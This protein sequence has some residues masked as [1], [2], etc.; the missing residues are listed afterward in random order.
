MS[1]TLSWSFGL[2]NHEGKYL[3]VETFHSMIN[4]NSKVMKKKQIFFLEKA[5]GENQVYIRTWANKYLAVDADGTFSA[6][7]ED[8]SADAALT[9]LPQPDGSWALVSHRLQYIHGAGDKM[10]ALIDREISDKASTKFVVH[11][12]MHPQVNIRNVNRKRYLHLNGD[13][14]TCDE[15]VPWGDDAVL[16]LDFNSDGSYSIQTAAGTFLHKD[17]LLS[18]AIGEDNKFVL[19]FH[20]SELAFKSKS[21]GMYLTCAGGEG[22]TRALKKAAGKDEL[23]I[24]EDSRPQ[25]KM[26]SYKGMK[27]SI[28]GGI[29]VS[30]NQKETTDKE[31]FQLENCGAGKWALKADTSKYWHCNDEGAIKADAEVPDAACQFNIRWLDD[32]IAL[33]ANN[34]KLIIVQGNNQLK[35]SQDLVADS[36]IPEQ[37]LFVYELINRP[38]LVLRGHYGFIGEMPSGTLE[39]NKST[40]ETMKMHISSGVCEISNPKGKYWAVTDDRTK[41]SATGS[42]KTPLYMEFVEDSKFAI[43]FKDSAGDTYYLKGEQ[44]GAVNFLGTQI[45]DFTLWEF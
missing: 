45:D 8:K 16:N 27:A 29:E 37:C 35:A 6:S 34:G 12:A 7:S 2:R 26:T 15:N 22:V 24:L 38:R 10:K 23:F 25:V 14:I 42:V 33:V 39:G 41:V 30:A 44:N 40:Y 3:T 36:A 20:H 5:E 31:V 9:I 32:K 1:D 4:C 28:K 11:L 21:S 18:P 17:G 43:R 19:E 13:S